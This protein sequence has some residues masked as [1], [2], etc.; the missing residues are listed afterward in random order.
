MPLVLKYVEAEKI[1]L[2]EQPK[3]TPGTGEVLVKV[4]IVG[5][6]PVDAE[7]SHFPVPGTTVGCEFAGTVEDA[8]GTNFSNGD[9]VAGW[10]FGGASAEYA[11]CP[12]YMAWKI[13]EGMS[14]EEAATIPVGITVAGM[15]LV[16]TLGLQKGE[17]V[18]IIGGATIMGSITIQ[19]AKA[20][21]ARVITS[22]SPKNEGLLKS[23]GADVVVDYNLPEEEYIAALKAAAPDAKKVFDA[24]SMKETMSVAGKVTATGGKCVLLNPPP[25]GVELPKADYE[26]INSFMAFGNPFTIFGMEVPAVPEIKGFVEEWQRDVAFPMIQE[27]KIKPLKHRVIPGGLNGVRSGWELYESGKVS[28]EKLVYRVADTEGVGK[29]P[30]EAQGRSWKSFQCSSCILC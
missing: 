28:A 29:T 24:R 6:N 4:E 15:T 30:P 2:E 18:V 14:L 5:G 1:S 17:D 3:P 13:P 22:A 27:G 8:N 16:M 11:T 9:R 7:L 20:I 21:G 26:F 10:T 23:L 19:V 25:D 12:T